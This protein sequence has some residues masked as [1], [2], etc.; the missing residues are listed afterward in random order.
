MT[1]ERQNN[2]NN[3][4]FDLDDAFTFRQQFVTS[5]LAQH[6]FAFSSNPSAESA[7]PDYPIS[8][9]NRLADKAWRAYCEHFNLLSTPE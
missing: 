6:A 1:I 5:Y 7:M 3:P 4:I 8:R 9:A 2:M